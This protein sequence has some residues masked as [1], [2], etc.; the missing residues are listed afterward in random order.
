MT[1]YAIQSSS[2]PE[3]IRAVY[4]SLKLG[5]GRFGWSY[6]ATADLRALK[7]RREEG[8]WGLLEK[9]EQDCYQGFLLRIKPGDYVVY[10]NVPERGQ[11][12]LA[13]VTGEYFFQFDDEDFNHRFKVDPA[14]VRE[15]NRNDRMVLPSLSVRLKLQGR[16]WTI[17]REGDFKQLLSALE[18]GTEPASATPETT[19]QDLFKNIEPNLQE[20]TKKIHEYHPNKALEDFVRVIFE[21]VPEV[22]SVEPQK[23]L[24][25]HGADLLVRF[26]ER[27]W[28]PGLV[29]RDTLLV[30]VKSYTGKHV[31]PSAV[32]DI[33]RAFEHYK[34]AGENASMGL[35]I[36]T[37]DEAGDD[38]KRALDNLQEK[39]GR[40]V[41]L[42]I[43]T[44][45]ARFALKYAGDGLL[46]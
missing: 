44:D 46:N 26:K 1:I 21:Q 29:R 3:Y 8:G 31:S 25:D 28:L 42:M 43:G 2:S 15:F 6:V 19:V 4:E 16:W 14:S 18:K 9:D 12:T 37:A 30:Q 34:E 39:T 33:E 7:K 32:N 17:Y 5:E 41:A 10:I 24:A 11:C 45:V 38:L 22:E 27:E 23:G 35:I 13:K 20:I 40:P 36:S